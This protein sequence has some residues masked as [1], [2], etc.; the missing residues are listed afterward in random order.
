MFQ[1]LD[2]ATKDREKVRG[3]QNNYRA[4]SSLQNEVEMFQLLDARHQIM[5]ET[6]QYSK[7]LCIFMNYVQ[8][9]YQKKAEVKRVM[10]CNNKSLQNH[11]M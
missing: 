6:I 7:K 3:K 10:L 8:L 4:I 2:H 1:L 5:I 9:G 11:P